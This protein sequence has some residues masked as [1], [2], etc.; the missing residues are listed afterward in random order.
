MLRLLILVLFS[1]ITEHEAHA[2]LSKVRSVSRVCYK[3]LPSKTPI[4]TPK[5]CWFTGGVITGLAIACTAIAI[6]YV[7]QSEEEKTLVISHEILS[8]IEQDRADDLDALCSNHDIRLNEDIVVA[9]LAHANQHDK[10][11]ISSTLINNPRVRK[12]LLESEK[13]VRLAFISDAL[14]GDFSI[15]SEI[16]RSDR[17]KSIGRDEAFFALMFSMSRGYAQPFFM[18][19]HHEHVRSCITMKDAERVHEFLDILRQQAEQK[20]E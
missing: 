13:G 20:K 8:A 18:L 15:V 10:L 1:T 3:T 4:F 14:L 5:T 16:L 19:W 6:Y 2:M 7:E 17:V 9:L 12:L 11:E